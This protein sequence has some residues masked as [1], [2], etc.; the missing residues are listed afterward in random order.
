MPVAI[1]SLKENHQVSAEELTIHLKAI[2]AGFKIPKFF[3]FESLPKTSTG[4]VQ[5]FKLKARF[6]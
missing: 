6:N 2:I 1:I 5:K 4:K 3:Y